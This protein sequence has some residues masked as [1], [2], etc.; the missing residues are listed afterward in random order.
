MPNFFR[1]DTERLTRT[2]LDGLPLHVIVEEE[3]PDIDMIRD[4]NGRP[5]RG[6]LIGYGL[7]YAVLVGLILYFFY[8]VP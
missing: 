5:T 3:I 2:E 7:A 1:L 6:G 4:S 8:F